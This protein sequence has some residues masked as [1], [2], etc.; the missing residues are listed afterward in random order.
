IGKASIDKLDIAGPG[1]IIFFM[2]THYLTKLIPSVLKAGEAF[3]ETNIGN[4]E[5]VQVEFVSANPTGDL[6]LGHAR[7]AAVGD[8]LCNV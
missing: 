8:S 4:G 7:G 1:F 3:G 2:N 5:R 6:L